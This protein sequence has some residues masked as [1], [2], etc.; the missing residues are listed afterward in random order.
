MARTAQRQWWIA[1]LAS[2]Q[3]ALGVV[4]PQPPLPAS[5]TAQP[6]SARIRIQ[7]QP[8]PPLLN[9]LSSPPYLSP[10]PPSIC[11]AVIVKG[12]PCDV[13]P[14]A[15]GP[16]AD[17]DWGDFFF[18]LVS[19]CIVYVYFSKAAVAGESLA[20]VLLCMGVAAFDIALLAMRWLW[21]EQ[22]IHY[23]WVAPRGGGW[24]QGGAHKNAVSNACVLF[25]GAT[26]DMCSDRYGLVASMPCGSS[27][28][29]RRLAAHP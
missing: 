20:A 29:E 4:C 22:Y 25:Q 16:D 3:P 8:K 14:L 13:D 23:G 1:G 6:H 26:P 17:L 28:D 2:C 10:S 5:V 11:C 12:H 7:D 9:S 27:A 19:M 24:G 15:G 18:N 21:W